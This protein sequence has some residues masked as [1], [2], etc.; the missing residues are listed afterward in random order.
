MRR[1]ARHDSTTVLCDSNLH[2]L[3][4]K[5]LAGKRNKPKNK[6][7]VTATQNKQKSHKRSDNEERVWQTDKKVNETDNICHKDTSM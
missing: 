1:L 3:G 6:N 7:S 4:T 2:W 5:Y